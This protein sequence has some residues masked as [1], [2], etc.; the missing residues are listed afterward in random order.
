MLN[1]PLTYVYSITT[2]QC[3]HLV[4]DAGHIAIRSQCIGQLEREGIKQ[5]QNQQYNK[6][7]QEK[8]IS[9]MYDKISL[10]LA[11]AQVCCSSFCSGFC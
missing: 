11:T 4:I 2:T 8:L 3:A 10:N 7:D 6:E 1:W 9:M 5:K